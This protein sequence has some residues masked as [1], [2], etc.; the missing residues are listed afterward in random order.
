MSCLEYQDDC[1]EKR[2]DIFDK[3]FFESANCQLARRKVSETLRRIRDIFN[4]TDTR[5]DKLPYEYQSIDFR[6]EQQRVKNYWK[7]F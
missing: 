5:E 2:K 7:R 4:Q 3:I 1:L 6:I